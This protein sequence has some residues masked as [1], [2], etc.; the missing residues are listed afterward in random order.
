MANATET[1]T[2]KRVMPEVYIANKFWVEVDK[3]MQGYFS[4]CSGLEAKTEVF[5]Y[6]EGGFNGFT[7]KL[8]TRTSYTNLT[9]KRG[10]TENE[11][12]W[13]WYLKTINGKPERK[14]ISLILYSSDKPG[15]VVRRWDIMG[16]YPIKWGGPAFNVKSQEFTIETIELAYESF[17]LVKK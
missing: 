9:L 13:N 8:P 14:N 11:D 5:E 7:H 3:V 16:A 15:D 6:K 10:M 2:A 1:G 4:E 17:K 12:F